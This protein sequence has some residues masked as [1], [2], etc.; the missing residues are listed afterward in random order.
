[1][2]RLCLLVL[3]RLL[4]NEVIFCNQIII[5]HLRVAARCAA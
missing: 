4:G 2:H 5:F 3:Q 1:M